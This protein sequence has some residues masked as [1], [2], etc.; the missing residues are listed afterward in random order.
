MY[1]KRY[2]VRDQGT[3]ALRLPGRPRSRVLRFSL[4]TR[5]AHA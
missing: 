5:V 4:P 1:S 3:P 2:A